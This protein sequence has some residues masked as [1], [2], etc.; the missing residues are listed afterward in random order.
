MWAWVARV[1]AIIADK[2]KE[3]IPVEQLPKRTKWSLSLPQDR[4]SFSVDDKNL[5][6]AMKTYSV[7]TWH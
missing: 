3:N 2:D 5:E 6:E 1:V 7:K 4:F